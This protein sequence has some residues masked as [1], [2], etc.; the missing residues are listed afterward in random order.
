M[1]LKDV[2]L[3]VHD[4]QWLMDFAKTAGLKEVKSPAE[5]AEVISETLLDPQIMEQ[6][7][8]VLHDEDIDFIHYCLKQDQPFLPSRVYY[9]SADRLRDMQYGFVTGQSMYF[10]MPEDVK[11][12]FRKIDTPSFH[13]RRKRV[14]WLN[15]CISLIPYLYAILST[16]DLCTLYRKHRGFDES[17]EEIILT[18]LEPLKERHDFPCVLRKNEL[19]TKGLQETGQEERL[20]E[21][22]ETLPV[23]F[24]SCGEIRDLTEKGYPVR[25]KT[26]QKLKTYLIHDLK[27]SDEFIDPLLNGIW[28]YLATG[29]AFSDTLKMIRHESIPV[30]EEQEPE[31]KRIMSQAWNDTRMIMC[32]GDTPAHAMPYSEYIF[33]DN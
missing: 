1:K 24:P 8:L 10:I 32:N 5:T 25:S 28:M 3:T 14:S 6:N 7:M 12:V 21:I 15:D 33:T 19:I 20:R 13:D 16:G 23:V 4:P 26:W 2:L 30:N 17:N 27:V 18:M 29:N 31:L 9:A 11:E 22:H